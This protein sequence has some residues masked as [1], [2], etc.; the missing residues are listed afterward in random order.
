MKEVILTEKRY[1]KY[2]MDLI[3][4]YLNNQIIRFLVGFDKETD[5]LYHNKY[6]IRVDSLSTLI[7]VQESRKYVQLKR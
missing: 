1:P 2:E 3:M 7:R 4:N 6:I 5:Y